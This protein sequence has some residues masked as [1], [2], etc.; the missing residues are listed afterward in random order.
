M[1]ELAFVK[2]SARDILKSRLDLTEVFCDVDNFSQSFERYFTGLIC[3]LIIDETCPQLPVKTKLSK[4]LRLRGA[5]SL[6]CMFSGK[7]SNS[8]R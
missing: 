7:S 5:N 2:V 3:H 8:P 6:C 1:L 4:G